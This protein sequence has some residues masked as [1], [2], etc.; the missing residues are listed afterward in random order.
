LKAI[1]IIGKGTLLAVGAFIFALP[2]SVLPATLL[3]PPGLR[4]G[5]KKLML[6]EATKRLQATGRIGKALV[7]V[8]R[9]LAADRMQYCR[10]NSFDSPA[11]AFQRGYGYCTQQTYALTEP[12]ARLGIEAK[13]VFAFRNR[14]PEGSVAGTLGSALW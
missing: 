8:A 4:P 6:A 2:L 10:R 1:W 3:L 9:S 5:I 12:P 14:F 11:K 13:P 7:E